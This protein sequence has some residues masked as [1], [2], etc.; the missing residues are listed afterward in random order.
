MEVDMPLPNHNIINAIFEFYLSYRTASW[1]MDAANPSQSKLD[2]TSDAKRA[3]CITALTHVKKSIDIDDWIK[4]SYE[5]Y[6]LECQCIKSDPSWLSWMSNNVG[7]ERVP[8]LAKVLRCARAYI[9]SQ[10][11][12]DEDYIDTVKRLTRKSE[13]SAKKMLD[14]TKSVHGDITETKKTVAIDKSKLVSLKLK[15]LTENQDYQKSFFITDV[16]SKD[17]RSIE[18][19]EQSFSDFMVNVLNGSRKSLIA[20]ALVKSIKVESDAEVKETPFV[21]KPVARKFP[22]KQAAQSFFPIKKKD[23]W[24]GLEA[25]DEQVEDDDYESQ[26]YYSKM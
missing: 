6:D 24:V 3:I 13:S 17:A 2:P 9:N 4:T 16:K 15:A 5:L 25:D 21:V 1:K 7:Q 18:L 14:L 8:L 12:I 23:E 19:N 11:K 26:P 10:I 22:P 20:A